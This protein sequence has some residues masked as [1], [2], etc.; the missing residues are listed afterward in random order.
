[1]PRYLI[2]TPLQLGKERIEPGKVIDLPVEAA[3]PLAAAGAV[4][5]VPG[6]G[7]DLPE[8]ESKPAKN[9]KG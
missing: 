7:T 9:R 8:P 3:A 4:E 6:A 2:K 1:M 5:A